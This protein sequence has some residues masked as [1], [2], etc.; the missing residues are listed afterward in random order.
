MKIKIES[1][2]GISLVDQLQIVK[3]YI[4]QRKDNSLSTP[5]RSGIKIESCGR[6]YHVG[7]SKTD[8]QIKFFIWWGV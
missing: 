5:K 2:E 3:D 1:A 7:C 8:T 4:M 6:R